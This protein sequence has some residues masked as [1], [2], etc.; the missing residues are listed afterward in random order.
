MT[1]EDGKNEQKQAQQFLFKFLRSSTAWGIVAANPMYPGLLSWGIL[2]SKPISMA[3]NIRSSES[4]EV[5]KAAWS[6]ALNCWTLQP[7][8]TVDRWSRLWGQVGRPSC[9]LASRPSAHPSVVPGRPTGTQ[10]QQGFERMGNTLAT[11]SQSAT[12]YS[13]PLRMWAN[14]PFALQKRIRWF[15]PIMG[16]GSCLR[17]WKRSWPYVSFIL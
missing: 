17:L 3:R 12:K 8:G 5:L 6:T 9:Y 15:F 13:Q 10:V 7:P 16:S 2:G 4:K 11:A 14:C 1:K